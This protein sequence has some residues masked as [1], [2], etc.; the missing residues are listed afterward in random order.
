MFITV[1]INEIKNVFISNIIDVLSLLAVM[2]G[3]GF[4]LKKWNTSI[5]ERRSII[6]QNLIEEVRGDNQ[7]ATVM[8]LID[9]NEDF[10]YD[11]RFHLNPNSNRNCLKGMDD[12]SLFKMIDKTLSLFSYICYM[13]KKKIILN[14]DI[15]FFDYELKRL[16]DNQHIT[17][18][19]FSLFHWS[20]HIEVE[21]SFKYLIDYGIKKKYL[22]KDFY[23]KSSNN[24]KCFLR[25]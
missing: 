22:S 13:K 14:S 3:G 23:S 15:V 11:G 7:I 17:N 8:D 19:L 18:Y 4:A 25:C 12:N 9:W 24:Y 2:I 5:K 16:F 21:M 6:V 10:I 1:A 20:K